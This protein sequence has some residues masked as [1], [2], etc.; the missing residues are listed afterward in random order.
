M[1]NPPHAPLKK[2]PNSRNAAPGRAGSPQSGWGRFVV[3]VVRQAQPDLSLGLQL[4][5]Q[6]SRVSI[7]GGQGPL[8]SQGQQL[9]SGRAVWVVRPAVVINCVRLAA[10]GSRLDQMEL[11]TINSTKFIIMPVPLKVPSRQVSALIKI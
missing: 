9:A 4:A 10:S 11:D 1:R 3:V 2:S 8:K 6:G 5:C 7:G